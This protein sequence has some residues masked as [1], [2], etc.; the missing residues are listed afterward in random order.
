MLLS[1]VCGTVRWK[2]RQPWRLFSWQPASLLPAIRSRDD[3]GQSWW[4]MLGDH[5]PAHHARDGGHV[6]ISLIP[7]AFP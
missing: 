4:T 2:F 1:V 3:L 6:V 5:L 7:L